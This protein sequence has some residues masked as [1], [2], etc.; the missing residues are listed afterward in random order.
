MFSSTVNGGLYELYYGVD[1]CHVVIIGLLIE[2]ELVCFSIYRYLTMNS[3]V[4]LRK[5]KVDRCSV[6]SRLAK[7]N[8][9]NIVFL[10]K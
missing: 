3:L 9:N 5:Y 1:T 6:V 4:S 10:F 8:T 2:E 7:Y